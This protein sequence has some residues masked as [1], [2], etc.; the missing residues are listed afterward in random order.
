M[1][2][3][4]YQYHTTFPAHSVQSSSSVIFFLHRSLSL[5]F[6][7]RSILLLPTLPPILLGIYLPDQIPGRTSTEGNLVG[8]T[9]FS[10]HMFPLVSIRD[11]VDTLA[12]M[13]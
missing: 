13:G 12:A 7:F 11:C 6:F 4:I 5:S 3:G 1:I 10:R 8:S 2:I 9:I